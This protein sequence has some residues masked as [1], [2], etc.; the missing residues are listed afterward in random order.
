MKYA[1]PRARIAA[2]WLDALIVTTTLFTAGRL[3]WSLIPGSEVRESS[4]QLFTPKEFLAFIAN[5]SMAIGFLWGYFSLIPSRFGATPGQR[6]AHVKVVGADGSSLSP[7]QKRN[8][9]SIRVC[10]AV[11]IVFIGPM[12]ASLGGNFALSM[13]GLAAPIIA[14]F[15]LSAMAWADPEGAGPRERQGGYRYVSTD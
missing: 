11:A 7:A 15:V 5:G 14:M 1:T 6:L 4:M 10:Q 9:A 3:I 8:R 12:L 2:F 13:I